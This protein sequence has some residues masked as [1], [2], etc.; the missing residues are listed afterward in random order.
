MDSDFVGD[1]DDL[2]WT[3]LDKKNLNGFFPN[4][5]NGDEF[6]PEITKSNFYFGATEGQNNNINPPGILPGDFDI[7]FIEMDTALDLTIT[8]LNDVVELTGVRLQSLPNDING[9]SLFLV[10]R[11]DVPD[12]APQLAFTFILF[13]AV[14]MTV[15]VS[16]RNQSKV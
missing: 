3:K 13:S 10:G 11:K 15:S 7:F 2:N 16:R 14:A 8:D 9:G 5:A 6:N 1:E 12:S 4:P